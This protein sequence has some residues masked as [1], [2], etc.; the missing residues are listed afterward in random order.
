M[1]VEGASFSEKI[2]FSRTKMWRRLQ[3][4]E[5]YVAAAGKAIVGYGIC[6]ENRSRGKIV[7]IAVH[8]SCQGLGLGGRLMHK[9]LDGLKKRGI[10]VYTLYVRTS[11]SAAVALYT[12][13]GFR[14]V[15][16]LT[17]HYA[18]GSDAFSMKKVL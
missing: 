3:Q 14:V 12:Q 18:D 2:A 1:A 15:R 13:L 16:T 8:P 5:A 7:S 9:V 17:G 10:S 4:Y 11:A 6:S